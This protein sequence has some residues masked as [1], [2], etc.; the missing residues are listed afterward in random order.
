M[1]SEAEL[2]RIAGVSGTIGGSGRSFVI[3]RETSLRRLCNSY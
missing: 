3:V 1:V 2:R